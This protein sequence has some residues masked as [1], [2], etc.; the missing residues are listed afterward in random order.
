MKSKELIL[1]DEVLLLQKFNGILVK[2][3]KMHK[4]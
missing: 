2:G 4:N 3:F 1:F